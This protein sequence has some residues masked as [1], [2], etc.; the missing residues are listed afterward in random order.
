MSV[1]TEEKGYLFLFLFCF[2]F[3]S[4]HNRVPAATKYFVV[5]V[6]VVLLVYIC[7]SLLTVSS[8]LT[9]A[10]QRKLALIEQR[11]ELRKRTES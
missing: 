4:W 5:V 11:K 6:D 10:A 2:C 9:P 7:L 8:R 3:W 1:D